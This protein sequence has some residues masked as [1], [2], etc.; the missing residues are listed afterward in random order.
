MESYVGLLRD[1][2]SGSCRC[3]REKKPGHVFCSGCYFALS[4]WYRTRLWRIGRMTHQAARLV[5]TRAL[6]ELGIDQGKGKADEN[7]A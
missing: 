4:E 6:G 2:R 3:G 5:Y 1:L 7:A